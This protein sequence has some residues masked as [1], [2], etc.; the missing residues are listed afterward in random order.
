MTGE[1]LPGAA[2]PEHL[3]EVL[4]RAGVLSAVAHV[5]AAAVESARPTILSR[6]LRLRLDYAGPAAGAPGTLILKAA[7]PSAPTVAG[8]RAGQEVAF[9]AQ[10]AGAIVPPVTPRCFEA[11]WDRETG[12]WRLLLEDLTASHV[13]ATPWPVAP[14]LAQRESIVIYD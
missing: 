5:R 6:I 1:P 11:H 7:C 10:V 8:M 13:I 3:T 14:T 2:T 9:Y 4:H 12:N